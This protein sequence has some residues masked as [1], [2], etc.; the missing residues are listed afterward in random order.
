MV[1]L[2]Q[3]PHAAGHDDRRL[4]QPGFVHHRAQ[5][6]HARIRIFRLLRVFRIR[7]AVV[8]PGQPWV[9]VDHA[10]EE[11]RALVIG[12]FPQGA[13]GAAGGND[14]IVVHAVLRGD[15]SE[16]VGH[17]RAAGHTLD[18]AFALLQH[19]VHDALGAGHLPQ[20]VHVQTA[21]AATRLMGDARLR[22]AAFDRVFEQLFVAVA[23]RAAVIALRDR[24]PGG[25][26]GIRVHSRERADAPGRS[27]SAGSLTGGDGDTFAAF[28]HG[29]QFLTGNHEWVKRFHEPSFSVVGSIVRGLRHRTPKSPPHWCRPWP[30]SPSQKARA[31]R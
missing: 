7:E 22:D 19:A 15:F 24:T 26:E 12:P 28:D 23:P 9:F 27:P 25:V 14:G 31:K 21:L 29:Q 17:S 11:F 20:D 6:R 18:Q 2:V 1:P 10:A 5:C 16:L 8:A 3:P 30:K 13:E 4:V